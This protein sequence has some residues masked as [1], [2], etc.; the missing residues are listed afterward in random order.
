MSD[1]RVARSDDYARLT[2]IERLAD[3]VFA[4]VGI[5]GL[6]PAAPADVYEGAAAVI[7]AGDPPVGFARIELKCG[8]AYLDQLSV[9]PAAMRQGIGAALLEAAV[10]W[11]RDNSHTSIFLATFRDVAWNAPFYSRHGF[12]E[13]AA[14]TPGM[15]EVEAHEQ[16][17]G[18]ARWGPRVLMQRAC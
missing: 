14:V 5:V 7:V 8:E 10:A 16:K 9:H 15:R 11:A 2:E 3:D 18:M 12:I 6:P 13:T 4:S 17:L 1:I